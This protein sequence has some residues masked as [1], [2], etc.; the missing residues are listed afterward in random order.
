MPKLPV[1]ID[2]ICDRCDVAG[3]DYDKNPKCWYCNKDDRLQ[4]TLWVP[5]KRFTNTES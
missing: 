3:R 4:H 2:Y 1:M 5:G